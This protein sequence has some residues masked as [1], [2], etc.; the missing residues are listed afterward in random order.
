MLKF[1][2][3][4]LFLSATPFASAEEPIPVKV[5][6][7]AMFEMG[8]VTGDRPGELQFWVEREDLS[9][10]YD[11][12]LGQTELRMS[13][14]GL[15]VA[16][17]GGGVT[18]AATTITALGMDPR[19]DFSDTYWI[20]AGIAG[21]DPNDVSLGSAAW[22]KWV[23]DGDLLYEIDA[24]EIP[25]DWPYGLI[26][27]GG[28][29][30]NQLDTGWTVDNIVF[31][32][33]DGLVN[34]AYDLT[35][36]MAVGQTKAMI[37]FNALF[38]GYPNALSKPSVII[39][40]S[41]SSSTYIHGKHLNQWANDWMKLHTDGEAEFVMTNM[42]DTGTLTALRR[43]DDA[44]YVDNDRILIL[45]TA[46]NYSMQPPSKEAT[47]SA[48][49]DYP[50]D[51]LPAL[52]AAY[53]LGSHVAHTI[54]EGWDT[55]KNRIPQAPEP[56][57]KVKAVVVTMF[58]IGE[59][60][61][62]KPAE[63]QNWVERYPLDK[64]IDFPHGYR[65]LRYNEEDGVLGIVTGIGTA[66]AAASIM[67]LGMD[68]RFDLSE[69][70]WLVA[71][72]AGVDPN[73]MS[74]GSAAWAEWLIDG[75]LSHEID[76]REIPEDWKYGYTPLRSPEY[77]W[78]TPLPADNEGAA[79][80]L[81]PDFVE[82]AYQLTKDVKIQD[83]EAMK[84]LRSRYKGFPNA[85]KPPFVLKGDQLA[86]MTFWHGELMNDWANDWV[87]YWSEGQGEFVTSAME[88]T[89]TMQ[90]L[91]F[92]KKAGKVDTDRVL[93]LRTASNFSMPYPGIGAAE[94]LSGE[95][96]GG[97]SAFIPSL[98]AAYD[99]GSKVI[100]EIVGNWETYQSSL[101]SSEK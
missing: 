64:K 90:S 62:D 76:P 73:D 3:P 65:D 83:T 101:P 71:G 68:P 77:P 14:D 98:E 54:I 30:P 51:G 18:H 43:L 21:A 45:R 35:K 5:V 92:L 1:I 17:T 82:W 53:K 10:V 70:Y 100:R 91:T 22:A 85:Q 58:E 78:K 27:L 81:K 23:V 69:A 94:N 46:S 4:L 48:T 7:L 60:S 16:L 59:D 93:V 12:P 56:K 39:G 47:W 42:E 88:E 96:K 15:M 34:W 80:R 52:E 20:I 84:A 32:L 26:P 9:N 61:G 95:K 8:E 75:D 49:A 44:G 2:I 29:E 87:D 67:A 74:L 63:F 89:G 13:D 86:A 37:E 25:E 57:K 79:Y 40:D 28:Y 11:F 38:E 6:A 33:N 72:I 97:Y 24:R 99:V 31:K 55:Y 50:D 41:L 66:R 19:F 36:D